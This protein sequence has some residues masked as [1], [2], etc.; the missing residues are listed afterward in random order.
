MLMRPP[1]CSVVSLCNMSACCSAHR[2]LVHFCE[3]RHGARMRSITPAQLSQ[4]NSPCHVTASTGGDRPA[5]HS[6]AAASHREPPEQAQRAA[7]AKPSSGSA[8]PAARAQAP[9]GAQQLA[10]QAPEAAGA[11]AAQASG[12]ATSPTADALAGGGNMPAQAAAVRAE[13]AA[14]SMETGASA[15]AG[16]EQ[17]P[18]TVAERW[19]DQLSA[20]QPVTGEGKRKRPAAPVSCRTG[21]NPALWNKLHRITAMVAW[22]MTPWH[23]EEMMFCSC[24]CPCRAAAFLGRLRSA[25][26]CGSAEQLCG[27]RRRRSLPTVRQL[28][29]P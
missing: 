21:I 17:L 16:Q 19:A 14:A 4:S 10:S 6:E 8:H 11:P 15:A 25:A 3:L 27:C 2:A 7:A 28:C 1:V 24:R 12:E 13:A 5:A 22:T 9:D 26:G 18:D 20:G 23:W 29:Y